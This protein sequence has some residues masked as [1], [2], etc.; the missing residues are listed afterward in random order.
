M[1]NTTVRMTVHEALCE[2]KVADKRI[3]KAISEGVFCKENK[4]SNVKIDGIGLEDYENHIKSSYQSVSDLIRRTDAIKKALSLSNARTMVSVAGKEMSVAEAIYS[5]QHGMDSKRALLKA[6]E[7]SLNK[8]TRVIGIENGSRLE[9]R[10]DTFIQSNFGSK[11]KADPAALKEVS[12][13]FVKQNTY[14]LVDP[15]GIRDEITKLRDEIDSF[16]TSVDSALQ[17]SNATTEIEISY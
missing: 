13:N 5:Y 17:M 15:L 1:G 11:D 4:Q 16:M 2:I 9:D 7:D 12:E 8:A 6:L 10:L 14:I 3:A